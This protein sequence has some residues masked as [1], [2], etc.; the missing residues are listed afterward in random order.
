MVV[1]QTL[2]HEILCDRRHKTVHGWERS[3]ARIGEIRKERKRT[4]HQ[5]EKRCTNHRLSFYL[6]HSGLLSTQRRRCLGLD[7]ADSS[8]EETGASGSRKLRLD[9]GSC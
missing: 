9:R 6:I 5:K 4:F 3:E 2:T 7:K 1:H 8:L